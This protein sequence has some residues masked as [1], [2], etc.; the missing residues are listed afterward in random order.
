MEQDVFTGVLRDA[1][2]QPIQDQKSEIRYRRLNENYVLF[3]F[4][5]NLKAILVETFSA[6]YDSEFAEP[7]AFGTLGDVFGS[8]V[9]AGGFDP[10]ADLDAFTHSPHAPGRLIDT[11][12]YWDDVDNDFNEIPKKIWL[13]VDARW[14]QYVRFTFDLKKDALSVGVDDP[15]FYKNQYGGGAEFRNWNEFRP[16]YPGTATVGPNALKSNYR[17]NAG[18]LG[19]NVSDGGLAIDNNRQFKADA[20]GWGFTQPK[21]GSPYSVWNNAVGTVAAS[22]TTYISRYWNGRINDWHASRW[23]VSSGVTTFEWGPV[24][25]QPLTQQPTGSGLRNPVHSYTS[26]TLAPSVTH[27]PITASQQWQSWEGLDPQYTA[28]PSQNLSGFGSESY[29]GMWTPWVN[30]YAYK[31]YWKWFLPILAK[32]SAS[33]PAR[34]QNFYIEHPQVMDDIIFRSF[35][36][37]AWIRNAGIQWRITPV[38]NGTG[39]QTVTP[40]LEIV[41]TATNFGPNLTFAVEVMFDKPLFV[42]GRTLAKWNQ[43]KYNLDTFNGNTNIAGRNADGTI[44]TA[45]GE[46]IV[47]TSHVLAQSEFLGGVNTNDWS[48]QA[49]L[50]GGTEIYSPLSDITLRGQS[51]IRYEPT[52]TYE[53]RSFGSLPSED[54]GEDDGGG[55]DIL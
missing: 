22:G 19:W 30:Q 39:D 28:Y 35:G 20:S 44:S 46:P 53:T 2:N 33:L 42:S 52:S 9:S 15:Y 8:A 31:Q 6:I 50:L 12:R 26:R 40:P 3:D 4:N 11:F 24:A 41:Q 27:D 29:S 17:N 55:G 14:V 18:S 32:P 43:S 16:W 54:D 34:W 23:A 7:P 47:S 21:D 48:T 36:D 38:A 51:V 25:G 5:I 37:D 45:G 10:A 1:E 13:G 49:E